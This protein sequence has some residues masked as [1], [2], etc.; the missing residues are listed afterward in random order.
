MMPSSVSSARS[1]ERR[2]HPCGC[3]GDS[4]TRRRDYPWVHPCG[5]RGTSA[6]TPALGRG[7]IPA[8]AGATDTDAA[9]PSGVHPCGCRGATVDRPIAVVAGSSLRV[10]GQ[11]RRATADCGIR[12]FIPA[13]AG[14][15]R[16]GIDLLGRGFIPARAGAAR[17]PCAPISDVVGFIPARAGAT[18]GQRSS[19]AARPGVHPCACRGS[20]VRRE[21][22]R[23]GVHPCACRGSD[24]RRSLSSTRGVHPCAC[25]GG[26]ASPEVHGADGFIPAGA[27]AT[28]VLRRQRRLQ[29]SSLRVQ[30]QRRGAARAAIR[31]SSLRVQGQPPAPD[32]LDAHVGVHPCGCRG[33]SARHRRWP[34]REGSSLRVQGRPCL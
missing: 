8:G 33:D 23:V 17:A 7:F 27:G 24:S 19:A 13:R 3:R 5:C 9:R 32:G 4:G 21:P 22:R 16:Q 28:T 11:P 15:T 30:G 10:Q 34:R 12:G 6:S 31:G 18:H 29:G 14:A 25:R 1:P 2:V 26:P 20:A